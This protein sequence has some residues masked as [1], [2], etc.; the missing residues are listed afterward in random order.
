MLYHL[1]TISISYIL[2]INH[3]RLSILLKKTTTVGTASLTTRC[4]PSTS[5]KRRSS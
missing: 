1:I 4:P 5:T 3:I 2:T